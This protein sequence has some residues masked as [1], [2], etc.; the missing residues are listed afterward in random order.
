MSQVLGAFSEYLNFSCYTTAC[1][2]TCARELAA[3]VASSAR[4]GVVA[5]LVP[6]LC[7]AQLQVHMCSAVGS[8]MGLP[9][10]PIPPLQILAD[11]LSLNTVQGGDQL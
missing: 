7:C 1:V 5:A 9:P 10:T 2:V 11:Q 6:M 8:E 4:R 3:T